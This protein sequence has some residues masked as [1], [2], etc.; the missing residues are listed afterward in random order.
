L[1][2]E[3]S[4]TLQAIKPLS[5]QE[6]R[7]RLQQMK[8]R[9]V[10]EGY[11]RGE[12]LDAGEEEKQQIDL[13]PDAAS[14]VDMRGSITSLD[15]AGFARA[16]L[17]SQQQASTARSNASSLPSPHTSL[18]LKWNAY[19]KDQEGMVQEL[20][21]LRRDKRHLLAL[22]DTHTQQLATTQH[23]HSRLLAKL[24]AL[25]RQKGVVLVTNAD[26]RT[27]AEAAGEVGEGGAVRLNPLL[28]VQQMAVALSREVIRLE[29]EK[30]RK[31]LEQDEI[32][33]QQRLDEERAAEDERSERRYSRREDEYSDDDEQQRPRPT[34]RH[35]LRVL[36]DKKAALL[37]KVHE[38]QEQLQRK[39]GESELSSKDQ[40]AVD[41]LI[42]SIG[43]ARTHADTY[44]E[45]LDQRQRQLEKVREENRQ[46]AL[47]A[48]DAAT[49]SQ[50][51][52]QKHKSRG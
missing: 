40:A 49:V 9:I 17:L 28:S 14:G 27:R 13:S 31:E 37:Q 18:A 42:G 1:K 45:Q 34:Q 7:V 6:W 25:A 52:A 5:G 43:T 35:R 48:R 39:G 3:A 51:K 23:K 8:A 46:L 50:T 24:T 19:A 11:S 44:E 36:R 16:A 47:H 15:Q 32:E 12:R 38:L 4:G 41:A 29:A 10:K 20:K 21:T 33:E 22:I 30:E 2:L 26:G